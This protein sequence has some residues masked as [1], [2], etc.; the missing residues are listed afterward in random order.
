M[1]AKIPT[2]DISTEQTINADG[3]HT[4]RVH[5]IETFGSVDGPGIRFIVFL[6]GCA[7]RCQYCH[8]PDTWEPNSDTLTTAD[9]LLE[10]AL[11][12]KSYWGKNGGITVSGGESL[13]QIDFLIEFFRK[14]K[15]KGINTCLD[16]SAQP[17]RRTGQFFKKFEELMQYTDLLLF[18]IKHIDTVEHKK[19]TGWGNENILDCARYLSEIN[20]PIWLRHVLVP[21]ITD[22]DE[23]LHRLRA[24]IEELHNVERIEVLPYHTLGI[25]KWENLN[26]PY[27]LKDIPEPTPKAVE[28]A[29]RVLEGKA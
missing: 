25:Y 18:D 8:N 17:F 6:K 22:N 26:L 14:A 5:S 11:R 12:Y 9:E 21:T 16:T 20:K 24:F 15:A 27:A 13:L 29:Q 2:I 7:M 3:T 19:L 4:A 10:K 1:M 23:Y 28:Y